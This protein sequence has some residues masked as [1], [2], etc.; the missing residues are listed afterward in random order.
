MAFPGGK[1]EPQETPVDAA[2]REAEEEVGLDR[3]FVSVAGFLDVYETGTG[4]RILPVV[5]FVRPGFTLRIHA[6]EVAEAFEVP[7]DFLMNPDNHQQ[8]TAFWRGRQRSYYAMPYDGHYIWGA[9]AGMLKNM[10][11]RVFSA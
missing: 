1:V 6:G 5:S 7:L 9:T 10:Y 11:D 2:L 4:F 8:H 3:S